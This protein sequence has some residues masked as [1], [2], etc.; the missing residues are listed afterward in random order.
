MTLPIIDF[1]TQ[2]MQEYDPT[3]EHRP[4]TA[5]SDLFIQPLSYIVQPIANEVAAIR[6]GQSI[7][8][9]LA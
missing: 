8:L 7:N 9:I 4:G 5:F 6:T 1:L 3:F 2:R